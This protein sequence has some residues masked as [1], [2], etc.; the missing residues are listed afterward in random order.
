[1]GVFPS[2]RLAAQILQ[3]FNSADMT[4]SLQLAA[5]LDFPTRLLRIIN[6]STEDVI[7][8][9]DGVNGHDVVQK[10]T[11]FQ[12]PVSA[13]SLSVNYSVSLPAGLNIYVTGSAGT[14]D[15]IICAYYQ[16]SNTP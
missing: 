9:Y 8:S 11:V 5:T 12:L 6:N 10:G 14:G 13:L 3:V 7:I 16:P 2:N 1:M 15:I 4:G